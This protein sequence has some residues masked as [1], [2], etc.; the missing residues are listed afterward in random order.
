[1]RILYIDIDSCRPDHLGCYGYH[2]NT[3]PNVD[4]IAA[5]GVR[6]TNCYATDAPCMPSRTALFSGRCGFHTGVVGHGGTAVKP[7]IEGATTGFRDEFGTTSFPWQLRQ[8]GYRTVTVSPFGERHS[9]W[10]WYAGFNEI[11]NTGKGG[12]E[13]AEEV[14][15]VVIDWIRR[16]GAD[17][18]WFMH[19]NVWDPHTPYRVPMEEGNAFADEPI[20]D[21]YTEEIR[22]KHW[23]GVGPHSAQEVLSYDSEQPAWI[24]DKLPRQPLTID[25]ME[26]ARQMFD[27][28]DM[29]VRYAD[30]HIGHILSAL[31]QQG[32]LDDTAII[33][34]ADHGENLGELNIYG[35]HQ[36]A[37]Q[38]TCNIPLI[39]R[40][41]GVTDNQAGRVDDALHYH[42]DFAATITELAGGE[43]S[44]NW[45]GTGFSESL[46]DGREEGRDFLVVSQG[47]WSCQRA[48][49]W[50]DHLLIRSYHDGHHMFPELM[51]FNVKDD[52][53]EQNNIAAE[54]PGL[55]QQGNAKLAEWLSEMMI[56]SRNAADPLKTVMLEG[57]P[58]HTRGNLE[59]Y[60]ERLRRTGR[61]DYAELFEKRPRDYAP[62]GH[63]LAQP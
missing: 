8:A 14:S 57:G 18:N 61:A 45:D 1:M 16:N 26:K 44:A 51:L 38:V 63:P 17:D 15:P 62:A 47:A 60:C 3:S 31:E 10:H 35:D 27:G 34:S 28:Y 30:N 59:Q 21:W 50:G 4:R 56:T 40:W 43:C 55:V 11:Y 12:H 52:P 29:G 7:F 2:R 19:I 48:V 32:V 20:P 58:F 6:F 53:H 49:R 22:E 9:A 42:L 37:D 24:K 36:T 13:N 5:Q 23:Q 39:I 41:P 54:N 46:R 33:I 25:S